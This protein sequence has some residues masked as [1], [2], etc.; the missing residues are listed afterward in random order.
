MR[1]GEIVRKAIELGRLHG[2][3]TFDQ[4]NELMPATITTP[5]DIEAVMN[6]LSDKGM[7]VVEAN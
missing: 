5:Q 1:R 7:T 4:L 3:V 2:F 6:A